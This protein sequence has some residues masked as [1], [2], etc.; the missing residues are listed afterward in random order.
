M[1]L[2]KKKEEKTKK[3][4]VKKQV[5]KKVVKKNTQEIDKLKKQLKALSTKY[6]AERKK[7]TTPKQ[8]QKVKTDIESKVGKASSQNDLIRLISLLGGKGSQP[9]TTITTPATQGTIKSRTEAP[10]KEK[11]KKAPA[12]KASG[13]ASGA[14]GATDTRDEAD[15]VVDRYRGW[16]GL[17]ERIENFR[18]K[19]NN[20]TVSMEDGAGVYKDI[21][22]FGKGIYEELPTWEQTKT[23]YGGASA[24]VGGAKKLFDYLKRFMNQNRPANQEPVDLSPDT[25]AEQRSQTRPTPPPQ[26]PTPPPPPPPPPLPPR[27]GREADNLEGNLQGSLGLAPATLLAGLG[28]SAYLYNRF[29]NNRQGENDRL[30]RRGQEQG[31]VVGDVVGEGMG[32]GAGRAVA[33]GVVAGG[34]AEGLNRADQQELDRD[35]LDSSQDLRQRVA[36]NRQEMEARETPELA[37]EWLSR[38]EVR[39]GFRN[40]DAERQARGALAEAQLQESRRELSQDVED[41]GMR[42]RQEA[43]D[44][45]LG[46]GADPLIDRFSENLQAQRDLGEDMM[47][48]RTFSSAPTLPSAGALSQGGLVRE[49]VEGMPEFDAEGNTII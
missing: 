1:V 26:A 13:G 14:S 37:R 19:Y 7:R 10:A 4:V 49:A 24:G 27:G 36:Q 42:M 30:V 2:K 38:R 39:G 12:T 48:E 20:G 33:R 31:W 29:L 41:M 6:L 40:R 46:M 34:L 18:D 22:K 5:V 44:E 8:Y 21:K 35:G 17:K 9:A 23:V 32:G 16:Q 43:R 47:S 3:K 45:G 11:E 25:S 15:I 28:A